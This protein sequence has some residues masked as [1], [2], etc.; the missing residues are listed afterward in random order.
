MFHLWYIVKCVLG[1]L[2]SH[3]Q[4]LLTQHANFSKHT[5]QNHTTTAKTCETSNLR[6]EFTIPAFFLHIS[7]ISCYFLRHTKFLKDYPDCLR[8]SALG[9]DCSVCEG[10]L[11]IW[12][13]G[14]VLVVE[15]HISDKESKCFES[16]TVVAYSL[17]ACWDQCLPAHVAFLWYEVSSL[18]AWSKL[19]NFHVLFVIIMFFNRMEKMIGMRR[20]CSHFVRQKWTIVLPTMLA[21][22]SD[23]CWPHLPAS[24]LT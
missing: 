3:Y 15:N 4:A 9:L 5:S 17:Q 8:W 14:Y 11:R 23:M 7:E 13:T 16:P 6:Q 20:G 12:K 18:L 1:D 19:K 24:Q 2:Q 22:D 21:H 10:S